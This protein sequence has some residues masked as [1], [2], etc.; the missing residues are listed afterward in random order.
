MIKKLALV[1]LITSSIFADEFSDLTSYFNTKLNNIL[2]LVQNK[3]IEKQSRDKQI[4]EDLNDIFDFALMGRLTIKKQWRSLSKSQK[5]RFI[6]LYIKRMQKSYSSK[7]DNYNDQKVK[8]TKLIK[9]QSNRVIIKTEIIG[10][11]SKYSVDYKFYKPR[12]Q[13]KDKYKWL[14]YDVAIEGNSMLEIDIRDFHEFLVAHTV[15]E[16]IEELDKL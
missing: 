15:Q 11:D 8:I 3:T 1:F 5:K 2:V 16:L 4:I 10:K 12:K 14:I 6:N 7:L 13:K 9:I